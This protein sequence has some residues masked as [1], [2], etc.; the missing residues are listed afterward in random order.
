[1]T[2]SPHDA[3]F[4]R[5]FSQPE[6]AAGELQAILP[7]EL[8]AAI[9]WLSLTTE[10]GSFIDPA[11]A[12]QHSDLLFSATARTTGDPLL[13]YVVFEHQSTPD[14]RMGLRLLSYM[15]SI[16]EQF[17]K[18][19]D[20]LDK[21]LPLIVP[22]LLAQVPG[23][24]TA[25]TQ[26]RDLFAPGTADLA[27]PFLPDFSYVVDDL[28]HAT[29]LDLRRRPL[30]DFP[31][32]A[33]WLMRD[34]RDGITLLAKLRDWAAL[35]ELVG[36][37][38]A[39]RDALFVLLRYVSIVTDELHFEEFPDILKTQSPTGES[40]TMTLA[41]QF[42]AKGRA[43]GR[44]EGHAEGQVA[45]LLA[46]LEA[47]GIVVPESVRDRIESTADVET[48]LRWTQRAV[49]ASCVDDIFHD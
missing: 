19:T 20:N 11:L 14:A 35:F 44:S 26:F 47:R 4:K 32:L 33:L 30:A 2:N 10:P 43:E 48:L 23:G 38:P 37:T 22:A 41:E 24:W 16:W 7:P 27:G 9:D 8:V 3:L 49:A 45:S 13:V 6:H 39:G 21:P 15:V 18:D 25:A 36:Q 34:A 5:V 12:G 28:D 31:R 46:V 29:D 40:L 1:M 17:A 42:I